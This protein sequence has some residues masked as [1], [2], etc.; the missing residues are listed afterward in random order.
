MTSNPHPSPQNLKDALCMPFSRPIGVCY[1]YTGLQAS[2]GLAYPSFPGVCSCIVNHRPRQFGYCAHSRNGKGSC[3]FIYFRHAY[4]IKYKIFECRG[5]RLEIATASS[6]LSTFL[7]TS[8][9]KQSLNDP[10]MTFFPTYFR[11]LPSNIVV[12]RFGARYWLSFIVTAWG[13]IQLGMAFVPSWGYLALCRVL[14]G[15]C[16]VI[17]LR[18][19]PLHPLLRS[20]VL[21]RLDSILPLSSSSQLGNRHQLLR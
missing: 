5:W 20:I 4:L 19:A 16:E 17:P 14:L 13:A 1:S 12:R 2:C 21:I 3:S 11:E 8:C 6:R 9:C 18:S 7:L 15:V 10:P